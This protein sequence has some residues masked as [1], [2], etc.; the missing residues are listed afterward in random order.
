[1]S[2][3]APWGIYTANNYISQINTLIEAQ[4]T[5]RDVI[6][7][8][9]ITR[10]FTSGDGALQSISSISGDTSSSLL[11]PAET[12]FSFTICF[13]SRYT[14]EN[15]NL[16]LM[17]KYDGW[18]PSSYFG[19][20]NGMRGVATYGYDWVTEQST[21]GILTN[22]L[23]MCGQNGDTVPYPDNFLVDGVKY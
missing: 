22:W 6:S 7:S 3:P 11:W 18:Y 15:K 4:G 21:V 2:G 10:G 9:P 8:G 13:I 17:N 1:V 16:L 23:V 20:Y 19:H 5:G 12:L 14:G